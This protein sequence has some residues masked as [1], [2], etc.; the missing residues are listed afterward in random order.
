MSAHAPILSATTTPSC[1]AFGE[2]GWSR[3]I[4]DRQIAMLGE[5]AEAG[6]Q[7]ALAIRD[8]AVG[9]DV[10]AASVVTGDISL[11]YARVSRAVRMTLALQIQVI[12]EI[13]ALKIEAAEAT[14]AAVL[15]DKHD[16][17][18]GKRPQQERVKRI[19]G[20]IASAEHDSRDIVERITREALERLEDED[21]YGD[22]LS[23][24][25]SDIVADICRDLGLSPDWAA[26]AREPWA[27]KER[28]SGAV[29]E[30][31]IPLPLEG[32]RVGMGVNS[33]PHRIRKLEAAAS[34]APIPVSSG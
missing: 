23:R 19:V 1:E 5:L 13:D 12:A 33:A 11:A 3:P 30:P 18:F 17:F 27:V 22:M 14:A 28:R 15:K 25:F 10:E 34:P 6:L 26:L 21:L 2:A 31:L 16:R 4:L 9:R 24:P 8:Q 32:G 7:I 20:R 29:G